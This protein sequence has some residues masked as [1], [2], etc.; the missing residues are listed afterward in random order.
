ME[1]VFKEIV[2]IM[3]HDYAGSKDKEG[4]V[5]PGYSLRKS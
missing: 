3:H 5:R 1:A 4:R 2:H